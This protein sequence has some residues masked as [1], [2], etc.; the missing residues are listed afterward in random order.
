MGFGGHPMPVT[1]KIT[2]VLSFYTSGSF[3]GSTGDMYGDLQAAAHYC[4]KEVTNVLFQRVGDYV[5]YRTDPDSQA[6]R[7]VRFGAIAGF[8]RRHVTIKSPT[9]Q[10]ATFINRKGFHSINIQ[11]VCDYR[12]CFLQVCAHFS[13]SSHDTYIFQLSQVPQL[14]RPPHSPSQMDSREQGLHM[15]NLD[16]VSTHYN[17]VEQ[18][19]T[20]FHGSTQ[21]TIGLLKMRFHCLDQSSGALQYAPVTV[22]CVKVVFY[23]LHNLVLQATLIQMWRRERSKQH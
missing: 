20:T 5:R 18:A 9:D 22:S 12:K 8:F 6:E 2:V 15:D 11:L 19:Y 16:S 17:A 4:I 13:G 3:Q 21:G 7:A 23:A 1:L 14:F 10:P